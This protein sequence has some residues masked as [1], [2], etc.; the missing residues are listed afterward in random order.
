MSR[1]WDPVFRKGH[2]PINESRAHPDFNPNGMRSSGPD[3][4]DRMQFG[5]LKRRELITL[6][7]GA[8]S[9]L[10][11]VRAARTQETPQIFASRDEVLASREYGP[12]GFDLSGA[13]RAAKPGD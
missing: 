5:Q 10:I 9:G 1:K 13:D 12:W 6:L 2:A 4:E 8:L 11:G 3:M 7:G